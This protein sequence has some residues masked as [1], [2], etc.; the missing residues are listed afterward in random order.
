MVSAKRPFSLVR[1]TLETPFHIDFAWWQANDRAWKVFLRRLLCPEH[2]AQLAE[3]PDD[4]TIDWIDPETAEVHPVD[5]LQHIVM[6]HCAL[7]PDFLSTSVPLVEAIFRVLL[8]SG[9]TP[10]TPIELGE[11]LQR[12]PMTILRTLSGRRVYYGIRPAQD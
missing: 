8:A 2:R 11:R 7:Q 6:T 12:P 9:N 3:L 4:E 10:M 5:A 1:P